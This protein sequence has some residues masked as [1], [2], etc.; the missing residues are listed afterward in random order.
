M[1]GDPET[2]VQDLI[3]DPAR[4]DFDELTD[5]EVLRR[6]A[7]QVAI[8][9][10]LVAKAIQNRTTAPFSVAEVT[11]ALLSIGACLAA[12]PGAFEQAVSL[13]AVDQR[14]LGVRTTP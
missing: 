8:A 7:R 6:T 3:D 12:L 2:T 10:A 1:S 11:P 14:G 4:N 9:T 5:G 13:H